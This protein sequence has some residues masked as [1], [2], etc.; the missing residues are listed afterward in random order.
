MIFPT[1]SIEKVS[2]QGSR[3]FGSHEKGYIFNGAEPFLTKLTHH[4]YGEYGNCTVM[5]ATEK[6]PQYKYPKNPIAIIATVYIGIA[7]KKA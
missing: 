3:K 5:G 2:F 6:S 1:P 4:T 7:G